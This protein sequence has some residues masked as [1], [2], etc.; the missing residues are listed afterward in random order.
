MATTTFLGNATLNFLSN[1]VGATTVDLSDQAS[2]CQI[3]VGRRALSSTAFGDTGERNTGGLM[4]WE[5]SIELYLS[6]G[7]GEVEATIY[8]IINSG[9]FTLTVSPSG[10]TESASNPEYTLQNGF[11]ESFTPIMSTVGELSV[12]SFSAVGGAWARDITAP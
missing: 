4:F 2:S 9:G 11:V 7:A 5:A 8:D 3:T 6:Y 12:L 1:A 10:T